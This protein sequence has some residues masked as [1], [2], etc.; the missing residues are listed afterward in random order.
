MP[1][2]KC[3]TQNQSTAGDIRIVVPL[4]AGGERRG[5][6]EGRVGRAGWR[7]ASGWGPLGVLHHFLA[8]VWGTLVCSV[9]YD[10]SRDA[11]MTC[12]CFCTCVIESAF[13]APQSGCS[14]SSQ[15]WSWPQ[16]PC[17][18]WLS[19]FPASFHPKGMLTT[20]PPAPTYTP[21]STGTA[22]VPA[23]SPTL[24]AV[25]FRSNMTGSIY[26]RYIFPSK[27]TR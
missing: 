19:V 22:L 4:V 6:R 1:S 26:S 17:V 21:L 8:R 18:I 2:L 20:S 5:W 12:A 24:T 15:Q 3:H 7:A 25:F 16:G 27:W 14:G 11:L 9:G 23:A 13:K 10:K